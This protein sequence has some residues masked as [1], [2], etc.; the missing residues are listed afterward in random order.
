MGTTS[1]STGLGSIRANAWV[2][3]VAVLGCDATALRA[4]ETG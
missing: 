1:E 2:L 4:P 3:A